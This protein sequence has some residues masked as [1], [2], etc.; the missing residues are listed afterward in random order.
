[1]KK[2][3]LAMAT[4]VILMIAAKNDKFIKAV[5]DKPQQLWQLVE[6]HI[7][8]VTEYTQESFLEDLALQ[9]LKL[10]QRE[11]NYVRNVSKSSSDLIMFISRHCDK[12]GGHIVL[13]NENLMAVCQ[14]AKQTV[15]LEEE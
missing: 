14:T 13:N 11:S 3:L 5:G 7:A 1:M 2:I 6:R 12:T 10:S 4:I 9:Q 8:G 15:L